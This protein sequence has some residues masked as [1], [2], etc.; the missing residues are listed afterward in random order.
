MIIVKYH[1]NNKTDYI[2]VTITAHKINVSFIVCMPNHKSAI[3]FVVKLLVKMSLLHTFS[4]FE[5]T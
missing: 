1:E 5:I 3:K 4:I 2:D